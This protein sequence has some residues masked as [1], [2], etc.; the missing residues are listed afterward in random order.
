VNENQEAQDVAT[1]EPITHIILACDE[2][3]AKGYADREE[4]YPGETGVFAGLMVPSDYVAQVA[5]SFDAVAAK[6]ATRE[7]K[8]HITDLSPEHQGALRDEMIAFIRSHKL[9]I[10]GGSWHYD[11]EGARSASRRGMSISPFDD[12]GFRIGRTPATAGPRLVIC[13]GRRRILL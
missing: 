8:L 13:L 9:L 11:P 4:L 1:S 10:R 6:Y 12:V 3:G 5:P 2:S 7:G